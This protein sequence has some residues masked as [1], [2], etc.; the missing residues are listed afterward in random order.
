MKVSDLVAKLQQLQIEQNKIL[1]QLAGT[2]EAAE[3]KPSEGENLH[4]GDHVVL[5]T[6]GND[7][8]VL[9][10][11]PNSVIGRWGNPSAMVLY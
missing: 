4:V 1:D 8:V 11:L 6:S 3:R 10:A 2:H 7:S 5:L 9:E